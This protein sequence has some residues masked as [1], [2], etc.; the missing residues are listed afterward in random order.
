MAKIIENVQK[1]RA[2]KM[3]VIKKRV[4]DIRARRDLLVIIDGKTAQELSET[5][6]PENRFETTLLHEICVSNEFKLLEGISLYLLVNTKCKTGM[7][8]LHMACLHGHLKTVEKVAGRNVTAEE[9]HSVNTHGFRTAL[10]NAL[11]N[12]TKLP[13]HILNELTLNH[14]LHKDDNDESTL[15]SL[16]RGKHKLSNKRFKDILYEASAEQMALIQ[17][18]IRK[19]ENIWK[20]KATQKQLKQL[21]KTADELYKPLPKIHSV[22]RNGV[23]TK[24]KTTISK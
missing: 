5:V 15:G 16:V 11:V 24:T 19:M 20:D 22:A 21:W 23:L 1:R 10:Q 18:D 7:T 8:P 2:K 17:Q 6:I 9:L 13:S 12:Q 3:A 14:L 4:S